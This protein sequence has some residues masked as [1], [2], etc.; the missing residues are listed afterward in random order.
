MRAADRAGERVYVSDLDGTLLRNDGRL[1]DFARRGLRE[2]L[3]R[4]VAFTVATARSLPAIREV[5]GDLPLRLPVIAINGAFVSDYGEGRHLVIREIAPALAEQIY[6]RIV[7]RGCV[8]FISAFDGVRDRLYFSR[9]GNAGMAWYHANRRQ[10]GDPRLTQIRDLTAPLGRDHIVSMSVIGAYEQLRPLA[11]GLE[12]E[13][14]GQLENHF[15]ENPYSPPWWWLTIHD[16]RACKSQAVRTVVEWAGYPY[17]SLVV[18]GDSLND[19]K[20]FRRAPHAVAVANASEEVKRHAD[21][22]IGPN[23]DDSVVRYVLGRQEAGG[24]GG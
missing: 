24:D 14:G 6:R 1:S 9:L 18:F 12:A 7:E 16:R 8:P 4:G 15:F 17:E 3:D 21:E 22:V 19:V 2:L 20:L 23:E 13:F 10:E 11:E 5:L